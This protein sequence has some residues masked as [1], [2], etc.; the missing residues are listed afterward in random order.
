MTAESIPL[1]TLHLGNP[2]YFIMNRLLYDSC[3]FWVGKRLKGLLQSLEQTISLAQQHKQFTVLVQ[4]LPLVETVVLM[5]G[6]SP[7]ER[8]SSRTSTMSTDVS[9]VTDKMQESL[10]KDSEF[11]TRAF[12]L[13]K[14][15][16][17]FM[18]RDLQEMVTYAEKIDKLYGLHRRKSGLFLYSGSVQT[19]YGGLA[20]YWAFREIEDAEARSR[21]LSRAKQATLS[22]EKLE[23]NANAWNFENKRLLLKV[24]VREVRGGGNFYSSIVP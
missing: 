16:A 19:F 7:G 15:F 12:L 23:V 18:L 13:N 24:S 22:I 14:M 9:V 1:S 21:W 4:F 6:G 10:R 5:I 3:G 2:T 20:S 8:M 17:S 11:Q